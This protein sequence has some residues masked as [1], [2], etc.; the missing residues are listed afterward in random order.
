MEQ[1]HLRTGTEFL[2]FVSRS[3]H[4]DFMRPFTY[5]TSR[6]IDDFFQVITQEQPSNLALKLEAFCLT[7]MNGELA[8]RSH[9][10]RRELM[11]LD[12]ASSVTISRNL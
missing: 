6:R 3:T 9:D 5:S 7:G 10:L 8:P 2:V 1:L 11:A 4:D 12:K